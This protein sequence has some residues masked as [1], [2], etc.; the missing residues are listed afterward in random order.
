MK[1]ALVLL[2]RKDHSVIVARNKSVRLCCSNIS[3][4][5]YDGIILVRLL[6]ETKTVNIK[7]LSLAECRLGQSTIINLK[8]YLCFIILNGYHCIYLIS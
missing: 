1:F 7:A 8:V 4:D 5:Q 6:L 2:P 3:Y